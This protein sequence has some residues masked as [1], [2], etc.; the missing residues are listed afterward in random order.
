MRVGRI[1]YL[2]VLPIYLPL[3]AGWMEHGFEFVQGPPA[4]LNELARA[5]GLDISSCSSVEYARN[6]ERY[7]LLP[8]LAIG[9][10]GPV[11]SVLLLSRVA[12]ESLGDSSVLV[13]A[14]T[15]TSA[16]LLRIALIDVYG[17]RPQFVAAPGSIREALEAG[18]TPQA[19][20]AIG[21]EALSLRSDKRF[22]HQID[23]GELWRDW[24]GLPFVFGVWVARRE[25][26]MADPAGMLAAADLLRRAKE[27]GV[28]AIDK[29]VELASLAHTRMTR[30]QLRNYFDHL[31]YELGAQEQAGLKRFF[32]SMAEHGIIEK[33]PELSILQADTP[34][35]DSRP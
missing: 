33:A 23:L 17:I 7:L 1:S 9:S 4:Q 25:S 14:E 13:T 28:A 35:V 15:H 29:V 18:A 21:D 11:K 30:P 10:K 26:W 2:N 5:G 16:V 3:E 12:P 8:D 32:A 6:P 34:G 20:L 24:T 22:S 27:A 31:S 19:V